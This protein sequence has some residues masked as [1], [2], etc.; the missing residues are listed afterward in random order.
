MTP[1]VEPQQGGVES[2]A[3][4]IIAKRQQSGWEE[5]PWLVVL[6]AAIFNYVMTKF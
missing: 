6:A 3:V 4:L 2:L 1:N 5:A